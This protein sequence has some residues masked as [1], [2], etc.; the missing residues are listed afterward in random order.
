MAEQSFSTPAV[1]QDKPFTTVLVDY[2]EDLFTPPEWV[3]EELARHGIQWIVGQHRTPEAALEAARSGDVV[4]V[5]SVRPLLTRA[6]IEQLERC[7]CI[8]RLGIGYDSV[9]VA[10]ATERGIP[11]CNIPTYCVDDVADHALAL[12]MD[13]VRH[14]ARQDRWIRAGR[15]DRTGARPSRRLKGCTLGLVAFGRIARALAQRVSGFG[16][17][18]L[19]YDPYVDAE[20]ATRY[21]VQ[22]V[23]LDELLQRADLIS[24]HCPLTEETRHLLSTR[25]F[26]LMK[27]GVF[28]VNTSRGPIIDEAALVEAL[29][30]GKVWG[31]GLDVFEHEPLPLDSPLR[32]FDNVTFTPHVGA[33]SEESTADLYRLGCQIAIDVYNGVWPQ[34]VVNPEVEATTPYPF[35]RQQT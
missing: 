3:G 35:R 15:W 4:M 29:R 24:V 32:D 2:D 25:E 19:T 14:I 28:I 33:N 12:L 34:S 18:L 16:L 9:D 17:T 8:V 11:V 26:N 27:E 20:T 7:R 30:S 13:A 5:Q 6:V 1:N 23:E 10:A 31:A 22:K 21:G